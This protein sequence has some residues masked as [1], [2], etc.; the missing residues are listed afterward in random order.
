MSNYTY[1]ASLPP[2]QR[3]YAQ[4]PGTIAAYFVLQF[5]GFASLSVLLFT[6]VKGG[7]KRDKTIW[8]LLGVFMVA[9]WTSSLV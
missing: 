1:L 8:S 5:F 2:S 6:F 9:S 3:I 7:V 4:P